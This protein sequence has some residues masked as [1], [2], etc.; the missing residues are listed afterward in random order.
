MT[1]FCLPWPGPGS[2][3][4]SHL[5]LLQFIA[6]LNQLQLPQ[7]AASPGQEVEMGLVDVPAGYELNK[8]Q[9]TCG[10]LLLFSH[11]RIK[12]STL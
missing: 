1:E 10:M 6:A 8:G 3:K 9:G 5:P 11:F 4:H 12:S 2:E 7:P